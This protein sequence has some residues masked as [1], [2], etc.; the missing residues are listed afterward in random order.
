MVFGRKSSRIG[1]DQDSGR[2]AAA[3]RP[4]SSLRPEGERHLTTV[5]A[6][7]FSPKPDPSPCPA[8]ELIGS[9]KHHHAKTEHFEFEKVSHGH[10]FYH[11]NDD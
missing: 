7:E 4:T 6:K 10:H 11:P 8:G 9:V 2:P 3:I 5:Y 1:G